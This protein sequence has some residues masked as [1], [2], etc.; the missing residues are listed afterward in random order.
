M[1]GNLEWDS[2]TVIGHKAKAPKVARNAAELNAISRLV[3]L[4][5]S[6]FESLTPLD[7]ELFLQA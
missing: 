7:R 5:D 1:S 4:L 2:K 3:T 6:R